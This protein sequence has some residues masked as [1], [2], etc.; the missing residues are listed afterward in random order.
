MIACKLVT[1][2]V[3]PFDQGNEL[4]IRPADLYL[5]EEEELNFYEIILRARQRKEIVIGYRLANA[6]RAV[7]NPPK[8]DV[9][10]KWSSKDVFVVIAE[11]E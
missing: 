7:V 1:R 10:R 11:K 9:R 8:K 3:L 4:Q 6:E 2:N 5:R